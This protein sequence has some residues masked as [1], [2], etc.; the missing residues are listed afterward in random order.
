MRSSR[1]SRAETV[2]SCKPAT[3]EVGRVSATVDVVSQKIP[4][5]PE[6]LHP[7][8]SDASVAVTPVIGLVRFPDVVRYRTALVSGI[9]KEIY[10][11]ANF[12]TQITTTK[13]TIIVHDFFSELGE[14]GIGD[15]HGFVAENIAGPIA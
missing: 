1:E 11:K 14:L 12:P 3:A 5:Q 8:G 13:P 4:V 6:F 15:I 10:E 9:V 7:P 2:G